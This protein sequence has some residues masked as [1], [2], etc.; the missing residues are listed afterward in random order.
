MHA[1]FSPTGDALAIATADGRVRTYD[2]GTGRLRATLGAD[3]SN[4]ALTE[5]NTCIAWVGAK[6][7]ESS[8]KKSV[9][10][11]VASSALVV[12]TASG[13]VK[14]Y[15]T[16]MGELKWRAAGCVDG[17]VSAVTYSNGVV[18]ATGAKSVVALDAATGE[19]KGSFEAS[20]HAMSC[21]AISPDCETAFGGGSVLSLW[22]ISSQERKAKF[23]GHPAPA[24]AAVFSPDGGHA[25]SAA[26][27]ERHVAV[28]CAAAPKKAKKAQGAVASL[29]LDDAAVSLDVCSHGDDGFCV[30]AVSEAGEAYVWACSGVG[31][32]A[33]EQRLLARVRVGT[34]APTK[35]ALGGAEEGIL[36]AKLT[37]GSEGPTLLVARGS[38]AKP[39]FETVPVPLPSDSTNNGEAALVSLSP[40]SGGLLLDASA[41]AGSAR[42]PNTAHTR[43]DVTV[44]GSE[45]LGAP[46]L[47]RVGVT[48]AADAGG[49]NKRSEPEADGGEFDDDAAADTP[50]DEVPLGQRVAELEEEG[51]DRVGGAGAGP[52]GQQAHLPEGSSKADSLAVLL[53]Q[54]LRSNDRALLEK[55]LSTSS[56]R[57]VVNT[58]RRLLPMDAALFLR[59]AV[60]RVLSKPARAAQLAPWIKAVMH[61]HTGYMMTAPGVQAPLTALYQAIDSRVGLYAQLLKVYGRLSLITAH[62]AQADDEAGSAG[63][64]PGPEVVFE[65][66]S[67]EEPEAE[68]PFAP[69]AGLSDDDDDEDDDGMD[70]DSEK[71]SEDGSDDDD[72]DNDGDDDLDDDEDD[73]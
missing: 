35:G 12:G 62:T 36:A 41:S 3:G 65:D 13:D 19:V 45:N 33:V 44:L 61:H 31:E 69:D 14:A 18:Y 59:A 10:S 73:Q 8:K 1:A 68:D 26:T 15:D 55:C 34:A 67:V 71:M 2:S 4:G 9:G 50:E 25:V 72:D 49:R 39:S 6:R 58:V 40:S 22:D 20:K 51:A 43:A 46:V 64:R 29:A 24:R 7:K 30:A 27:G 37:A 54:A 11:G 60:D 47:T 48:S 56:P 21:L 17:S 32:G 5:A 42:V 23:T 57:V 52:S 66:G 28:W 70:G 53:T 38:S 16:A 63:G